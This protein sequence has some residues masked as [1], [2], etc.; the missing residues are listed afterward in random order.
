MRGSEAA[1]SP[2]KPL[3]FVQDKVMRIDLRKALVEADPE[4][5]LSVSPYVVGGHAYLVGWVSSPAEREKLEAEHAAEARPQRLER[6]VARRRVA[7]FLPMAP[8]DRIQPPPILTVL[9]L[10]FGR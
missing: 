8:S 1:R 5:V 9:P 10:G 2:E 4:D 6:R 7:S 3:D